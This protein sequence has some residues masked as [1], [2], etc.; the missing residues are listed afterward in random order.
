MFEV[1]D[2]CRDPLCFKTSLMS[3]TKIRLETVICKLLILIEKIRSIR[4]KKTWPYNFLHNNLIRLSISSASNAFRYISLWI[5]HC[6]CIGTAFGHPKAQTWFLST[7]FHVFENFWKIFIGFWR[8]LC[9]RANLYLCTRAH[10]MTT[11]GHIRFI[12]KT[13]NADETIETIGFHC[14]FRV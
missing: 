1:F 11:I 12:C 7:D 4:K 2:S 14:K 10:G 9:K 3:I 6:V 13:S 5:F 8:I